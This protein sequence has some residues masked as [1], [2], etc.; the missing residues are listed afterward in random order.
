MFNNN[1]KVGILVLCLFFI[2]GC[3]CSTVVADDN[4]RDEVTKIIE[5]HYVEPISPDVLTTLTVKEMLERLDDPYARYLTQEEYQEELDAL[6]GNFVGVGIY[7][8]GGSDGV[9]VLSVIK[10]SPAEKAGLKRNDVIVA[11]DKTTLVGVDSDKAMK[12]LRGEVGSTVVL[13]VKRDGEILCFDVIREKI[14]V[15]TVHPEMLDKEMA[16]LGIDD[17]GQ[18]TIGELEKGVESLQK[19]KA[20]NWIVDLRGNPGWYLESA[21]DVAGIFLGEAPVVVVEER[22]ALDGYT[23]T[24]SDVFIDGPMVLLHDEYSASAAEILAGALRDNE[25]AI[26][27]GK[28]TYG[29]GTVQQIFPLSNGDKLK[30]TIARFYSPAGQEI[31][32][33]GIKPDIEV[34]DEN[35]LA[36]AQLILSSN[37][38][39]MHGSMIALE[40][41]SFVAA[42]DT[43]RLRQAG[44]WEAWAD[45]VDGIGDAAVY[46]GNDMN[47]TEL[48]GEERKLQWSFYY[49]GY[50]FIGDI[51]GQDISVDMKSAV[52]EKYVNDF[53]I[54]LINAR[55]GQ[56]VKSELKLVNNSTFSCQPLKPLEPGEYWLAIHNTLRF[57]HGQ[58]LPQGQIGIIRIP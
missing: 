16:Y 56:R 19:A 55:S 13:K 20:D 42:V 40:L 21:I 39:T 34:E 52:N 24:P 51:S 43:S 25:R 9:Q 28:T 49:P 32:G 31:N 1:R 41:D 14:E 23:G 44:Y 33:V 10:G 47:W 22:E 27:I 11:A 12:I 48:S 5:E 30:I 15:P 54:Q 4:V 45:I 38:D 17:F 26:L 57:A 58:R 3:L 37:R 18:R 29:K 53:N 6:D 7:I 50:E 35:C 8:N 46:Y 2:F 36:A